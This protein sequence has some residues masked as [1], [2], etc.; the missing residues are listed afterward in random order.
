M[1]NNTIQEESNYA[2]LDSLLG[3][4]CVVSRFPGIW[5]HSHGGPSCARNWLTFIHSTGLWKCLRRHPQKCAILL[6]VSELSQTEP[7]H[8]AQARADH[9][10]GHGGSWGEKEGQEDG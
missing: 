5:F 7:G 8:Q 6:G 2:R 1:G 10:T 3:P 4:L 9:I